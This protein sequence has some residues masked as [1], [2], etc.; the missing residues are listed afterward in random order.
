MSTIITRNSAT[1]G[2]T[3][4]SLVQGELA[5]NVKDGRLFYG[6]GSGNVVKEFTGS[7]SGGTINTGSFVTTSSFNAYTGSNTS[8]FAGTA[9][10]ALSASYAVS[11]SYEINYETSSSYADFAVSASHALTASFIT[12]S[13]VYGPYGSNSVISASYALNAL[14]SSYAL[15]AS[16]VQ[17]A[18]SASYALNGGV[19]QLLAG[20]N[21]TLSPTNG[22]GQVTVSA[23]LSGSTIFNTATGSYGSFYDTTIQTNPVANIARSMSFNSTD[24]TNGVSISGSTSPFNTYIKTT[25]AG[26]YDIQFS[27][28]VDKTDGGTDDI[29]IWLRKNGIDLTD[30]ATTL[31]LP[32]NNSKVVAAW[33]WFVSS[34]AGDYYQIIWRSADTDLRLLAE[35]I[36]VDHPGI[37][38]VILTVN[39]VDQFLSNTGSFSGSF[40]GTFTGSL[41]GTSSFATT[42]SYALNALSSSYALSSSF[43][44]TVPASGVIGLNLSQIATASF[45]ASVSPTQFTVTSASITEFTV[46]GTGVT[47]GNAITDTHRVTGSLAITGSTNIT[48]PLTA[49]QIGAGAAPSGSVPL[50]VRAQGALSTDLA[51]RVRNSINTLDAF[52]VQGDNEVN[53]R[54]NLSL[55]LYA[56]GATRKLYMVRDAETYGIDL[57][58]SG[59]STVGARITNS[60]TGTNI[61][62][63]LNSFNGT[64]NYALSISNGDISIGGAS[65]TKIGISNTQKLSFW[66]ATPIVQPIASTAIDTLLTNTGLRA[67][68]GTANFNTPITASRVFISSSNGTV[69]GSSLTVFGS[70]SAQPVFTVQGSQGE[71]FSIT[72]SLSGSLF[73]VNDI[74]G[75]PILEVFSDNTTLIGNYQDPMLITTAKVV[76]TNSGSF[77]LYS[78]PTASYDTAFF[79]YSVKSG[80]NARA[81]TI[82]A[83][84]SGSAVNFTETTT[85]DFGNTTAITFTVIVTGSNMAITGSS[86][87]GSWTIKTIVRGL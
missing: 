74:S 67:T 30:T 65:G 23:T 66:N 10:F 87:T 33:N 78:L 1:S 79:E 55:G 71:L 39:R 75:L 19:T 70:G 24:I 6:S 82:M 49:T 2:S 73:S 16:F 53:V 13:G 57:D 38:S 44:S 61:A 46:T 37:P 18:V 72:D 77:T 59:A 5:I 8:Q 83:I 36:S 63:I 52:K 60:G 86:T 76:Q 40:T 3:P 64:D 15:T 69:S 26:V 25:N 22:L 45:T 54:S 58:W 34:A 17:N 50:D 14:S 68:G 43:A 4:S 11:A 28:Q 80:S 35:S 12:A 81:G 27:A 85:T 47:I 62:L 20:P 41:S 56:A 21:V 29:V 9:S 32:T 84:Q 48:G 42:A 7:G 51:F 31:T